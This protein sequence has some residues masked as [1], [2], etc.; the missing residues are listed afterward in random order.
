MD[1]FSRLT[2]FKKLFICFLFILC[3]CFLVALIVAEKE[4]ELANLA[5]AA[6]KKSLEEIKKHTHDKIK[7]LVYEGVS[8][9]ED[10]W[11]FG[12]RDLDEEPRPGSGWIVVVSK[13]DGA[14]IVY[15]GM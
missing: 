13:N 15:D 1:I 2:L 7:N 14:V 12:Y 5:D 10:V 4:R 6:Q 9:S 8:E 11:I 3:S